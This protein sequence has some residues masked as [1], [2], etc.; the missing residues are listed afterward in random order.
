MKHRTVYGGNVIEHAAERQ[1]ENDGSTVRAASSSEREERRQEGRG[2]AVDSQQRDGDDRSRKTYD[3]RTG[4]RHA[5]EREARG[6]RDRQ[7]RNHHEAC[8]GAEPVSES[9][10]EHQQRVGAAIQQRP[11]EK[12]RGGTERKQ[13]GDDA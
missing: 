11:V 5:H 7:R 9:R 4:G 12:M 6:D 3:S 13:P 10:Q 2:P 1:F 8:R